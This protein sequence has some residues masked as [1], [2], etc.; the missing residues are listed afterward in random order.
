MRTAKLRE[1]LLGEIP[2]PAAYL[3]SIRRMRLRRYQH[4]SSIAAV[5]SLLAAIMLTVT[6]WSDPAMPVVS[7]WCAAN[8]M[9]AVLRLRDSAREPPET[10][11]DLHRYEYTATRHTVIS[12]AVWGVLLVALI[13]SASVDRDWFLGVLATSVLCIGALLHA[14]FPRAALGYSGL[15]T[16]GV[17]A[18]LILSGDRTFLGSAMIII[19]SLLAVQR[20]SAMNHANLVKRQIAAND[21]SESNETISL[22]LSDFES[23]SADWL[24]RTDES[25]CVVQPSERFAEAAELP[26]AQLEGAHIAAL[27]TDESARELE[28][29]LAERRA[30]TDLVVELYSAD[31]RRWWSMSGQPVATGGYRGVCSDITQQ[32]RNEASIAFF[33]QHDDLT[34]LPNRAMLIEKLEAATARYEECGEPYALFHIDLDNF[35][36]IN[37][38]MGH[39][40]GDALLRAV[41]QRLRRCLEDRIYIVRPGGDEFAVLALDCPRSEAERLGDVLSDAMLAPLTLDGRQIMISG[42]IG[43]AMAPDDGVEPVVLMKNAELALYQAKAHGRGCAR[44]FEASMDEDARSRAELETGLRSAIANDDMDLYFQPLVDTRTGEVTGYETLLRWNRPGHGLVSPA[45][46][47]ACAE[48]TGI[49]VPLG[50][51]VV[52]KAIEEA[53]AWKDEVSVAINLSPTQM[54]NPSLIP[55]VVN[56]L[57]SSQLDPSRLEIEITETVLMNETEQNLKTLHQLKKLGVRIALDDFGTGFSSLS[58]LRA[59]PFDKLKID[60]CFVRDIETSPENQ[61]IVRSVVTLARDLGMNITAEGVENEAQATILAG[62]GCRNVQGYLYSR[63]IPASELEKKPFC[64]QPERKILQFS[65]HRSGWRR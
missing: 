62:L 20:F 4:T 61:A 43:V 29:V 24:W 16:L 59:F 53:A 63:P 31:S 45:T 48:E 7:M 13:L 58:Y 27:L 51:W 38:T 49:I 52:R 11:E 23:H 28:E 37:D 54:G 25:G 6:F 10:L 22:L 5:F 1:W 57:A 44:F 34:G 30:F 12:G 8:G 41:A 55:T 46:F 9:L 19:G 36:S 35:K 64:E 26:Y 47:I 32:R 50:E 65:D 21:L 15:I 14:S 3:E 39:P 17:L 18:A 33:K 56:A 60:Q 2:V 42:S 40:S